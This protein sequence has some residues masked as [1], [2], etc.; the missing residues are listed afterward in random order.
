MDW[1]DLLTVQETLK[2]RLQD[3]SSK[4]SSLLQHH[5]SKAYYR[6]SIYSNNDI[7]ITIIAILVF[8]K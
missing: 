1:F 3:Y 6:F 5:T 2:S 4:A 8:I 7:I